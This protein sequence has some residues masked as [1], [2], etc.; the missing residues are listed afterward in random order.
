MFLE[1]IHVVDRSPPRWSINIWCLSNIINHFNGLCFLTTKP[2]S[3]ITLLWFPQFYSFIN[4]YFLSHP[5]TLQRRRQTHLKNSASRLEREVFHIYSLIN[6][7]HYPLQMIFKCSKV[8][9]KPWSKFHKE[10]LIWHSR[11]KDTVYTLPF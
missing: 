6:R 9:Q 11:N 4:T 8:L 1:K 5:S 7:I 3:R 10:K 2:N